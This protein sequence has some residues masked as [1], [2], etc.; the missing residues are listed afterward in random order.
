M[1]VRYDGFSQPEQAAMERAFQL[2]RTASGKAKQALLGGDLTAYRKWFDT[3]GNAHVMK[4][5][6]IVNEMDQ[7]INN[8]PITFAKLDR[9]GVNVNTK[10]LCAYVFLIQA[11]QYMAHFGS[12]MRIMV[13]WKTH[14]GNTFSYLAQTM[15]HELSHKVGGTTD[16]NYD[17]QTCAVFA[18]NSPATAVTNAENFNLFLREYL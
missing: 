12:G 1:P 3:S 6:S 17:E 18:Q 14:V 10:S 13:V 8:R 11:G 16:H 15:Y 2:M 9:K 4:V 7:A 5:A